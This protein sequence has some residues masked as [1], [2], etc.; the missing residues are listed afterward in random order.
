MISEHL[1]EA[2]VTGVV[3][4]LSV[5]EAEVALNESWSPYVTATLT[6]A[7][8]SIEDLDT[9]DPR[10]GQRVR[11]RLRQRFGDSV[12]ARW[13]EGEHASDFTATY[14]G[15]RASAVSSD[16]GWPYNSF[17]LRAST[18][19]S[20][21]LLLVERE[22]DHESGT[23]RLRAKSDEAL[24]QTWAPLAT[25]TP[26]LTSV[27]AIVSW[28]LGLIGLT[29]YPG[30]ADGAV[31]AGATTW[32]PGVTAWDYLRPMVDKVGLRLWCDEARNLYLAPPIDGTAGGL[33]LSDAKV[34][35]AT[36]TL[37]RDGDW[38]DAVVIRYRWTDVLGATQVA[39]DTA[40]VDGYSKVRRLEVDR[41][42][43]GHGAAAALLARTRGRGRV[44]DLEAV[45]DYGATPGQAL[46][47]T[48]PGT[49]I[50]T[51][52]VS[53]V[54]WRL[55]GDRM[56][57]TTRDLIDTPATSWLFSPAGRRW[58]DIPVGT[59]WEEYAA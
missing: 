23:I 5:I 1:I 47:A 14:A 35:R 25:L 43:P 59:S 16:Y 53:S 13:V 41:P 2:S 49:P 4:S 19:R 58:S 46:T 54:T 38:F 18:R 21:D 26:G 39:Y 45:S 8:P 15:Q 52:L 22:V 9:I 11:I 37:D 31:E 12:R 3:L 44:F 6:C 50:Q 57:I 24:L 7:I 32:E 36:D 48:L 42:F 17:G 30:D 27:R 51:G 10:L 55:P 40:S 33:S 34:T 20:L 56:Q 28:A 29:L